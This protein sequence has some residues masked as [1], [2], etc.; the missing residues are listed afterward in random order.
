MKNI[1]RKTFKNIITSEDIISK[2]NPKNKKIVDRYIKNFDTKHS[3][4]STKVAISNFNIFFCWNFVNNENKFFCDIKK[5]EMMDFFDY[6]IT[7]MKWGSSRYSNVWSSLN[8]LSLFIENILDDDFPDFR[9]IVKKIEKVPKNLRRKKTILKDEQID[10][11]LEHLSKDLESSQEACMLA[12]AT[13]SGARISELFRFDTDIIDVNN[14]AYE[15]LFIETSDM[16]KT[17]GRG[18][19]GTPKYKYILKDRFVPYYEIWMDER[20]KILE[21][22]GLDHKKLFIKSDGTPAQVSTARVW[23][24]KWEKYLNSI[25]ESDSEIHIYMHC[26][27]HY[28]CSYLARIGLESELIIALFGWASADMF[29]TYNDN[30]A[31][32]QKWK[33][34]D[35]LKDKLNLEGEKNE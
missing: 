23:V 33:G 31:K 6:G 2:I 8:Q 12:L 1:P 35:K 32:D 21:A 18:K 20:S 15:N 27:R 16:I 4:G 14:T 9:N 34:L 13:F 26:L 30:T 22:N 19:D 5:S 11:L 24:A 28:L 10:D 7:E 29:A 17:K 3:D 25:S